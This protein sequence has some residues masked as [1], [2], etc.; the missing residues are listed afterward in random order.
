MLKLNEVNMIELSMSND[1]EEGWYRFDES[2]IDCVSKLN[3]DGY[4]KIKCIDDS[5]IESIEYIG[6]ELNI[7]KFENVFDSEIGLVGDYEYINFKK[8][9][10]YI[11][12]MEVG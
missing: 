11:D 9:K 3:V 2:N 4:Y 1:G 12:R 8:N 10:S 6:L 5:I 7:D